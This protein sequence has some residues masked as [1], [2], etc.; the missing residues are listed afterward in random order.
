MDR[1]VNLLPWLAAISFSAFAASAAIA[2]FHPAA[3]IE[4]VFPYAL[5]VCAGIGVP[6]AM[7]YRPDRTWTGPILVGIGLV[8]VVLVAKGLG[9][10]SGLGGEAAGWVL[11]FAV[12]VWPIVIA[13]F[14]IIGGIV[15][16]PLGALILWLSGEL[17]AAA[18]GVSVYDLPFGGLR[19]AV[20]LLLTFAPL[21]IY[22]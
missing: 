13:K 2:R 17:G 6:V 11:A 9:F 12:F 3:T 1:A 15:A 16:L 14:A 22:R 19:V 10:F 21:G 8:L 4:L 5:L 18:K 20:L 7:T